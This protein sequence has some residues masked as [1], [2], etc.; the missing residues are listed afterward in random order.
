[1]KTVRFYDLMADCV[2]NGE[3][4]TR[5]LANEFSLNLPEDFDISDVFP[6]LCEKTGEEVY[7]FRYEFI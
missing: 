3:N 2:E 6:V 4:T 1:M 5:Q 7:S